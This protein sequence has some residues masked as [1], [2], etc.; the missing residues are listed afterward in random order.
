MIAKLKIADIII[1]LKSKFQMAALNEKYDW[2]YQN[3]FYSGEEKADINLKIE[4]VKELPK[5]SGQSQKIFTTVHPLS[6]KTNWKL[7]KNKNHF[8][9]EQYIS[10]KNQRAILNQNFS[11]GAVYL[12]GEK[13]NQQWKISDLIYDLLQIILINYLARNDGFFVH[14][15]GIKDIDNVGF[16]FPAKSGGGKSTTARLWDKNSKAKILND[17]RVIVRK[18][19][20]KFFIFG[21][22]WHG[23]FH[24]YLK[25]LPE[26]AELKKIF[27]IYHRKENKIEKLKTSEAFSIFYPN[28][29]VTFWN[30]KTLKKQIEI[31]HQLVKKTPVFYFGFRKEK[32]AIKFVRQAK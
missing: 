11:R 28:V 15:V 5:I 9:I 7:F 29:F 3:F 31:C 17:D 22:P 21:T 30:K 4:T 13:K 25:S 12:K 1:N 20:N 23:D 26:K 24:D 19:K 6:K 32:S 8:I 10:V 27:L 18:I 2:R 14:G 16:L